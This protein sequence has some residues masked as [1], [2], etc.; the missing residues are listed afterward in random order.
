[1]RR[2]SVDT[3]YPVFL[4]LWRLVIPLSLSLTRY[5]LP[6][7]NYIR[8]DVLYS[9]QVIDTLTFTRLKA[10]DFRLM[11]KQKTV[12]THLSHSFSLLLLAA[13]KIIYLPRDL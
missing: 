8:R 2:R 13:N 11:V 5:I 1:M 4:F 3:V 9:N 7:I 10:M 12:T 6:P